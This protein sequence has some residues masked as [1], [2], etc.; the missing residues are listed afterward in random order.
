MKIILPINPASV[1]HLFK[2]DTKQLQAKKN[3]YEL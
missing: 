1:N 3:R 2:P